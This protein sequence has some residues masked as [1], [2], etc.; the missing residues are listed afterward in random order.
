MNEPRTETWLRWCLAGYAALLPISIALSQ[1]PAFA[2]GLLILWICWRDRNL[3]H[4][5]HPFTWPV[6]VFALMVVLSLLWSVRPCQTAAKLDRL[7]LLGVVFAIP[8]M[9]TRGREPLARDGLW[10]LAILFIAGAT[11]QALMD[12]VALPWSYH[13]AA[14]T[15]AALVQAGQLSRRALPPTLFDMGNMRDPQMYMV[16]LSLL[17]GWLLYRKP[18]SH[19]GWWWLA[20]TLNTAAFVLHFKRGAWLAFLI[21]AGLLAMAARRRRVMILLLIAV[22]VAFA[23]PQV[24]Q[25]MG[26]LRDEMRIKTGGR[27][28]LWTRIAAPMLHD[29]PWGMGWKAARHEDFTRYDQR[30][31]PKLNHLHNNV[32]QLRLELGWAGVAAWLAWM[33]TGLGVM[34]LTFRRAVRHATPDAGLAYGLLGGFLALQLNGLV[35]YNFGDA[36]IFMLFNLLLGLAAAAWW[37]QKGVG[38]A[39]PEPDQLL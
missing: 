23:F 18:G 30:I 20:A 33:L 1:A 12:V 28:V 6:A 35:E 14:Q 17:L 4:P 22:A 13:Q 15:H 32:L 19:L 9:I 7:L 25:R 11:V 2:A 21:S 5:R 38:S 27:Y 3:P 39:M 10:R 29:Y 24:R 16:S 37:V 34:W 36:E 26:L 31:Q 8:W